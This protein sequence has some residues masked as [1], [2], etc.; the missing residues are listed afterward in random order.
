MYHSSPY[1]SRIPTNLINIFQTEFGSIASA[2]AEPAAFAAALSL[3]ESRAAVVAA[4]ILPF[5]SGKGYCKE[6]TLTGI[7]PTGQGL[8][9]GIGM[10]YA[11]SIAVPFGQEFIHEIVH[12]VFPELGDLFGG[13]GIQQ[14]FEQEEFFIE[15]VD[16]G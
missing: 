3:I 6:T 12:E 15:V 4:P 13:G 10:Q 16:G 1:P 7:D 8:R 11:L 2:L 5:F 14:V 9:F